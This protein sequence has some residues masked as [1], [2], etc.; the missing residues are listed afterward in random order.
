MLILT[1]LSSIAL[2]CP[3][4]KTEIEPWILCSKLYCGLSQF[5]ETNWGN[6]CIP[7]LP[8]HTEFILPLFYCKISFQRFFSPIFPPNTIQGRYNVFQI[9]KTCVQVRK[10]VSY[11]T[12][13]SARLFWYHRKIV[14]AKTDSKVHATYIINFGAIYTGSFGQKMLS[15]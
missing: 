9:G 2:F 12:D 1:H 7:K 13:T 8:H 15:V 3:Y 4:N 14:I 5:E 10:F 6:F 11:L